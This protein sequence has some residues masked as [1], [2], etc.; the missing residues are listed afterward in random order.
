MSKPAAC[1]DAD[2]SLLVV[3]NTL[4]EAEIGALVVMGKQGLVGVI[5]ERD[6]VRAVSVGGEPS[7][8]WA[9]D[10]M[11]EHPV[12]VG[13]DERVV[14]VAERLLDAGIR[15]APVVADGRLEGMVSARDLLRVLNDAW[16]R[17][18]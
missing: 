17:D 9:S 15:H 12:W 2:A 11:A 7:A 10:V 6:V 3:A 8:L 4:A 16:R 1:V 13:P 18:R 5:S 14:D